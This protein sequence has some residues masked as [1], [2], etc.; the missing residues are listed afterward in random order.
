MDDIVKKCCKCEKILSQDN[1]EIKSKSIDG[2]QAQ[3]TY[4]MRDWTR[5]ITIKNQDLLLSYRKKYNFRSREKINESIRTL[6]STLNKLAIWE[7]DF[8]AHVSRL[9]EKWMKPLM[10]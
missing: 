3:S 10:Y 5:N 1:L 9:L 2:L 4:C 6:I 7:Y 8:K